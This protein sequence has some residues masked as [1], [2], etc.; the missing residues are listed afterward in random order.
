MLITYNLNVSEHLHRGR[1]KNGRQVIKV[2]NSSV[3]E[4]E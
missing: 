2:Y 4:F 3:G 1:A